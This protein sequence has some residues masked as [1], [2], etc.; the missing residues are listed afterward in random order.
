MKKMY[1]VAVVAFLA[2]CASN[3][4]KSAPEAVK[5]ADSV[6]PKQESLTYPYTAEY[7]SDFEI[8][9]PKKAQVILELY[10]NWDKNTLDNSKSSF[11]ENDTMIFADGFMFAGNR[12]SLFVVAKKKRGMMGTVV[13]SIHAWIPLRSKDKKEDWVTVWTR[14]VCTD[15]KGKKTVNEL[16]ETWRFDENGKIN[17]M[18]QY[19]QQQPKMPPMPPMPPKK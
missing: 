19:A 4:N 13:D 9:D 2:A 12:D 17:L 7:S 16:Q 18:Y 11:A 5:T 8:G 6:S 10:Q 3:T 1:L 14:E 15:A